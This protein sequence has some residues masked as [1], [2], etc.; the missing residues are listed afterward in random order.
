MMH[1]VITLNEIPLLYYQKTTNS[2]VNRNL[3]SVINNLN[4]S[5]QN[6]Y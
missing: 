1:G 6:F 3:V 2:V 5:S 4:D